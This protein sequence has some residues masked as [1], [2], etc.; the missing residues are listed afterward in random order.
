M[1]GIQDFYDDDCVF[2]HLLMFI[3]CLREIVD[4]HAFS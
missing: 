3:D 4:V 2:Q 1:Y